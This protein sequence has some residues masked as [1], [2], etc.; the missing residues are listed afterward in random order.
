MRLHA[1]MLGCVGLCY[2]CNAHI[3][4]VEMNRFSL[5]PAKPVYL[6]LYIRIIGLTVRTSA[7]IGPQSCAKTILLFP[8]GYV[9][10]RVTNSVL[11]NRVE[12][13]FEKNTDRDTAL[14][15]RHFLLYLNIIK[16]HLTNI[17]FCFCFLFS[18]ITS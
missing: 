17:G 5:E 8:T 18:F 11:Y 4:L 2:F 3:Y 16:L 6:V 1:C 14:Y 15:F 13:P 9:E 12:L 10:S 7:A